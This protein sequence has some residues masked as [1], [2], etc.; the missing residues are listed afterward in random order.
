MHHRSH[1][2]NV[3]AVRRGCPGACVPVDL[4]ARPMCVY[5]SLTARARL[6]IS[7]CTF[8]KADAARQHERE[9]YVAQGGSKENDQTDD[10]DDGEGIMQ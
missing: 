3:D 6:A 10:G 7:E 9:R 8:A 2:D 5:D 4:S 1:F